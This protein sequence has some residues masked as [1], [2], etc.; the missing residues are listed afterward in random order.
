M[1]SDASSRD[2]IDDDGDDDSAKEQQHSFG[3][4]SG[5]R[6][7]TANERRLQNDTETMRERRERLLRLEE[8]E[9]RRQQAATTTTTLVTTFACLQNTRSPR[10]PTKLFTTRARANCRHVSAGRH[11]ENFGASR[12]LSVFWPTIFKAII[13]YYAAM[14]LA[15][16]VFTAN[17]SFYG[18][19]M[20]VHASCVYVKS[21]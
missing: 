9:G 20:Q 1:L 18:S 4:V 15:H 13:A 5:A 10:L 12:R 14:L 7:P 6:R 2:T 21:T 3:E 16:L 19:Q 11:C 17:G 8:D